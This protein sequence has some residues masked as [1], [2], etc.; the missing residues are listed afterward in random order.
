MGECGN[1]PSL[2][3]DCD[4]PQFINSVK[5]DG[6]V[7][8]PA[9][10]NEGLRHMRLKVSK[11]SYSSCGNLPSLTR[12]CDFSAK[13]INISSVLSS[14]WKPALIKEGLRRS[15]RKPWEPQA[16]YLWKPA[17]IKEGLRPFHHNQVF[18]KDILRVETCPH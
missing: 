12:D 8:K 11:T 6:R 13:L 1:L 15:P 17:L 16:F 5:Q 9:L 4:I 18:H 7:W 14:K 2:T 10:I 3:R